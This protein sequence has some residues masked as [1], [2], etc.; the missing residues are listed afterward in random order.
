MT[1][2]IQS[3]Y[4]LPDEKHARILH[5]GVVGSF[6]VDDAATTPVVSD[7]A[8]YSAAVQNYLTAER[9]K[10]NNPTWQITIDLNGGAGITTCFCLGSDDL[11]S[12][13][14]TVTLAYDD[15]GFQTVAS[16]TPSD[17][18]PI[19]F[20]HDSITA[21]RWRISGVGIAAPSIYNVALG[22][23]LV[24]ERAFYGGY[25]PA[26]LNR[27]TETINNISRTG[28]LL[29][30][31]IKRTILEGNYQWNNLTYDWVRTNLDT[32]AG[33]IQSL[34][35]YPAYLAWRPGLVGDVDYLM[36]ASVNAP[37]S[38]GVRNLWQFSISAEVHSY[39]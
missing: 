5:N 35:K 25:S 32:P 29:G 19:M 12:T 21:S 1:V 31:S 20:L 39:E 30:R 38:Q 34:E 4:S 13:G 27:K 28:E 14:Q 15:A 17:N 11:F 10:P 6:L 24:M 2:V 36:R 7:T 33:L 16:V 26:R 18:S 22:N 8:Y 23:P 9:Y 3:G 37:Q